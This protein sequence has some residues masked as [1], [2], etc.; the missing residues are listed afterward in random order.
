MCFT[1]AAIRHL[2]TQK[3]QEAGFLLLFQQPEQW[4]YP[5][6][7]FETRILNFEPHSMRIHWL[8]EWNEQMLRPWKSLYHFLRKLLKNSFSMCINMWVKWLIFFITKRCKHM[9]FSARHFF[10]RKKW[11]KKPLKIKFSDLLSHGWWVWHL[12]EMF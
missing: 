3:V 7:K 11:G 2:Q 4:A 12:K 1:N 10:Q 8:K 9:Y 6:L 5:F